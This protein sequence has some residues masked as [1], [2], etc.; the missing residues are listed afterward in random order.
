MFDVVA[1]VYLRHPAVHS[2]TGLDLRHTP[3]SP[4]GLCKRWMEKKIE[5][6]VGNVWS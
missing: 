6:I 4:P 1:L 5:D 2:V 3:A